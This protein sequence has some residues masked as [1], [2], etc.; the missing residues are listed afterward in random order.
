MLPKRA[1]AEGA[2]G[3][4]VHEPA[5]GIRNRVIAAGRLGAVASALS[6]WRTALIT[7][8][9]GPVGVAP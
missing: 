6:R 7:C 4:P 8:T 9:A 2:G 3:P 1:A 5:N